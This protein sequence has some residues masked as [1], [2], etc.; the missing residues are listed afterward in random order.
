MI[1]IAK[2]AKMLIFVI[3][4]FRPPFITY[5]LHL[6]HVFRKMTIFRHFCDF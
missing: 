5:K 4:Y 6:F 3:L 2:I 1:K